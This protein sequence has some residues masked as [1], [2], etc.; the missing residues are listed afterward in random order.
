GIGPRLR[1]ERAPGRPRSQ[2]RPR[3]VALG[4]PRG[5]AELRGGTSGGVFREPGPEGG[6]RRR[7]RETRARLR[8]RVIAVTF[9]GLLSARLCY[10]SSVALFGSMST[11]E[12][13]GPREPRASQS[14]SVV[15]P[16]VRW[17]AASDGPSLRLGQTPAPPAISPQGPRRDLGS[18]SH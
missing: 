9:P 14:E 1:H 5:S 15:G 2:E 13:G 4:L 3:E 6:N 12:L 18:P 7:A 16:W 10:H 8:R 11:R 17:A